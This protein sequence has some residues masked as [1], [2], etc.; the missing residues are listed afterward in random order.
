MSEEKFPITASLG[1]AGADLVRVKSLSMSGTQHSSA[2]KMVS[3]NC[4]LHILGVTHSF[5][6]VSSLY[7][8]GLNDLFAKKECV[9]NK[10]NRIVN[11]ERR[12]SGVYSF[13][14]NQYTNGHAL[15]APKNCDEMV[16]VWHEKLAQADRRDIKWAAEKCAA[17]D[18]DTAK[19]YILADCSPVFKFSVEYDNEDAHLCGDATWSGGLYRCGLDNLQFGRR[20]KV[21]CSLHQ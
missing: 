13:Q 10:N 20:S 14:L 5:F 17:Q 1:I 12:T 3:L 19:L 4:F 6:S 15:V 11:V 18:I 7:D 21:F 9:I 16:D 8:I 2:F